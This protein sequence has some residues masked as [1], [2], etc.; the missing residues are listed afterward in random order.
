MDS[1][2][3]SDSSTSFWFIL[4]AIIAMLGQYTL[5]PLYNVFC[6]LTYHSHEEEVEG[7]GL[8]SKIDEIGLNN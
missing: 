7:T 6:T 4:F 3:S 1:M 2:D 5:M 8:K